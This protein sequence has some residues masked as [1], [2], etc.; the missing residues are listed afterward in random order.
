MD[1]S[2]QRIDAPISDDDRLYE[3]LG[4]LEGYDALLNDDYAFVAYRETD[5]S[6][7]EYRVRIQSRHT[8]GAVFEPAAIRTRCREADARGEESFVWGYSFEPS[9]DDPRRIEFRV[10]QQA[11]APGALELILVTRNADGSAQPAKTLRVEGFLDGPAPAPTPLVEAPES[12]AWRTYET[13]AY[14]D[15][16]DAV[17]NIDYAFVAYRETDN[18]SGAW[19][20]MVKS[21]QTAGGSFEPD[22]IA[23]KARETAAQG[24]PYFLWGYSFATSQDD[25]RQIDFRIHQQDGAPSALEIVVA[26][27]NADGSAKPSKSVRC[28]WPQ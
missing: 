21:T 23:R 27:R 18:D 14:L 24:L 22:A 4:Y 28:P 12:D 10:H 19:R 1:I 20:I 6:S 17:L 7:G 3:T 13:L 5:R 25:P 8:A 2:Q 16:Y 11:G 15:E 9:A 26:L